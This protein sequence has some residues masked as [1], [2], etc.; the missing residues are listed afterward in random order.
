MDPID[1]E[2]MM[3]ELSRMQSEQFLLSNE[4]DDSVSRDQEEDQDRKLY[5][6]AENNNLKYKQLDQDDEQENSLHNIMVVGNPKALS[7]FVI[8]NSNLRQRGLMQQ[9]FNSN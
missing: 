2:S 7:T 3:N 9:Q 4:D 5:Q 8:N 1:M 6:A